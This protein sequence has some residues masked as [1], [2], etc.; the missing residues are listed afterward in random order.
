V[1]HHPELAKHDG[2]A[3][4]LLDR[5]ESAGYWRS[6][7]VL[8]VLARDGNGIAVDRRQAYFHF[9][10]AALQGGEKVVQLLQADIARLQEVLSKAEVQRLDA[11][12]AAWTKTHPLKPYVLSM[13]IGRTLL[14]EG[15]A[16][17]MND[18]AE[19]QQ[20]P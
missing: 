17:N 7:M 12:A 19:M 1:L 6:S 20:L 9:R 14:L 15:P 8:G 13:K 5:A 11:E 4:E 10:V 18:L 3:T 16:S 2:D